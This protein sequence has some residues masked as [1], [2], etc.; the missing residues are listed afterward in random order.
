VRDGSAGPDFLGITN[1][2]FVCVLMLTSSP[3]IALAIQGNAE[4][5]EEL[6][7]QTVRE[8][9]AEGPNK[10]FA[11]QLP[12]EV[13]IGDIDLGWAMKFYVETDVFAEAS[14]NFADLKQVLDQGVS[15]YYIPA[16]INGEAYAAYLSKVRPLVQASV[17]M[18]LRN[19]DITEEDVQKREALVGTWT[20][21]G[22][23]QPSEPDYKNLYGRA[24]QIAG[25]DKDFL[26][27]AVAAALVAAITTADQPPSQRDQ[28]ELR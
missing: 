15:M 28:G 20:V 5:S 7:E 19:G 27:V 21:D 25:P 4:L 23:E 2:N 11:T 18:A 3:L 26:L 14:D 24:A 9:V 8:V 22:G 1:T 13:T 17:E 16:F 12:R 6:D 10:L